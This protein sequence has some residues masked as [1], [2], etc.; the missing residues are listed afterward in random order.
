M[1][2]KT[3]SEFMRFL[4]FV[5]FNCAIYHYWG[6]WGV[7]LIEGAVMFSPNWWWVRP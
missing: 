7:G 4:G 2:D 6:W 1:T 3:I 5:L